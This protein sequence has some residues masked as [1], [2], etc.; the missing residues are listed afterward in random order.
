MQILANALPGFRDMRAPLT[1]G[2]LWL[3]FTWLLV[4]PDPSKRP[5][6]PTAASVYDLATHVGPLWL[7]LG[8]GVVAYFLG[9]VSQMATDYVEA[10]YTPSARS[11]RQML[12]EFEHDPSHKHLRVMQ[13][14]AGALIQE[15]Y[16]SITRTLE[17]S[18]LS[19]PPDIADEA[20][21]RIADG[22][23]QAYERSTEE[24]ELP[25]TLLVG[26]EPALFAEVD[27]MRAEGELRISATPPLALIIVIL[28]LQ[29][30]PW[31][32][33]ALP[34]VAALTY[35]GARRKGESRQM[36]ID[37]MRMGRVVSPAAKAYQDKMN[38]LTEELRAIGA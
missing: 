16:S 28:A 2:Y 4:K 11:R 25:A 14:P 36:I 37:A 19:V 17:Q 23:R 5:A 31:F 18:K 13:M 7:G 20:E 27:R 6:N 3:L 9:A 1:T 15:T 35:Q 33:L 8:A 12:K 26:D 38:R 34:T 24:L 22:Q 32:W 21:W 10:N 29:V 30:S